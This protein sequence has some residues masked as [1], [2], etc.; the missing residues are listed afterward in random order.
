MQCSKQDKQSSMLKE[1]RKCSG[2]RAAQ[3]RFQLG[4]EEGP[5]VHLTDKGKERSKKIPEKGSSKGKDR[6]TKE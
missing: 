5:G 4:F 3:I 1:Q 6:N 2:L